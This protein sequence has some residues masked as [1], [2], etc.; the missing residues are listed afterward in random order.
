MEDKQLTEQQLQALL[1]LKRHEQPPP[2]YFDELL[3]KIHR[4]QREEMLRRPAWRL[5]F[6]RLRAF[7]ASLRLDW[8]YAATMGAIL[9]IGIGAIRLAMP[10]QKR[11]AAP[12]VARNTTVV[13]STP[14]STAPAAPAPASQVF[15]VNEPIIV[16]P[17]GVPIL[18]IMKFQIQR[19]PQPATAQPT[20]T[21]GPTR[22][23]IEAQ[24]ASYE[25]T[26]IR[27]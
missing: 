7:F 15:A 11:V 17:P 27:F 19:R 16:L 6:D 13:P 22:F 4:R 9:L 18:Q 14:V 12:G 20:G 2:G 24:P 1:R 10:T 23:V 21:P 8:N 5:F 25:P 3:T 26:Q